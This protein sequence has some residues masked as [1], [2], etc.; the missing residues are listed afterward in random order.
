MVHCVLG[1]GLIHAHGHETSDTES[2]KRV[3]AEVQWRD[4]KF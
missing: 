3:P 2:L 4:L 1:L